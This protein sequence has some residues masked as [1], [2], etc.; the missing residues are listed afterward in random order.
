MFTS[1]VLRSGM[2]LLG[3]LYVHN[4]FAQTNDTF[5]LQGNVIAERDMLPVNNVNITIYP[6]NHYVTTNDKGDFEIKVISGQPSY[7]VASKENYINDTIH[8]AG[9]DTKAMFILSNF[10]NLNEATIVDRKK[11]TE[12]SNLSFQKVENISSKELMKAA[13]CNL[14]ESFETTPSVDVGFTD[15]VSGYKQIQMLGLT[16]SHTSFTRENIPDVR[17]LAAITGLTFTP[18]TFVESMQLSKGTGSVVNGY[19]GTAG[20]INVEWLKPFEHNTPTW[21]FNGYQSNQGR[22]E[23]NIIYS[24]EITDRL[25]TN[26]FV[27]G[28]SNWM[29]LDQNNDHFLDQPKGEAFVVGNRW[30]YFSPKNIEIQG[31]FKYVGM[32]QQGGD[33]RYFEKQETNPST[34]L[35]NYYQKLNR[36]DAWAKVGYMHPT[37]QWQSMG[38]QL[39]GTFHDQITAYGLRSYS[40]R[41]NSFYANYIY[42]SIISNTNHVI[43]GGAS[44]IYDK[45]SEIFVNTEY[46]DR[47]EMV[48][49][50]FAEY[51][52]KYL[53]KFNLVA[54]LRADFNSIYGAFVTPRLHLRY[55]PNDKQALRFSVGRAQRTAN[56]FAE[57]FAHMA[58]NRNFLLV[59]NL[60]SNIPYGLNPEVAWNMGVNYTYK[61]RLGYRDGTFTSDYYYTHFQNQIVVDIEN[62][63]SVM[64]FNLNGKSYAHSFQAQVDY[65]IIPRLDIRMAYRY[66]DVKTTM[67]DGILRDKALISKH[68]AFLNIGYSTRN[69]WS[70]DYTF[71]VFGPK[72]VPIHSKNG[73]TEIASAYSKPYTVMNAQISKSFKEEKFELYA[74]MENIVGNMQHHMILMSDQPNNPYFDA[75]LIWGQAMGRNVYMGF[76]YKINKK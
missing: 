48:P 14:S 22:S 5:M 31:G 63:R 76:R 62:P 57:N 4:S 19:E 30:F 24:K 49:G 37:K 66:Y 43:K 64:F 39:S 73:I 35:W 61:F 7:L 25:S 56:I 23:A 34:Y 55:A 1:K 12:I 6:D 69:H 18:G 8:I 58:S 65:E 75:S 44:F 53:T 38:L 46:H 26:V 42:Q 70:F 13:C 16:G 60:N 36:A 74:G 45:Y 15:A 28:K 59:G 29:N 9:K 51:S 71:Q 52:Y 33:I 17:G 40:A 72:R 50:V 41:Q 54:G 32:H 20:Q 2:M 27:H 47:K 3:S 21:L 11:A 68:R 67:A 10:N